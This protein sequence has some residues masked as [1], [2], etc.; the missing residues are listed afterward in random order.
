[1]VRITPISLGFIDVD[2]IIY[3]YI[4]APIV[5]PWVV[6]NHLCI[7]WWLTNIDITGDQ[8]PTRD[9]LHLGCFHSHGGAPIAVWLI[10]YGKAIYKWMMIVWGIP[11]SKKHPYV[12]Y[13]Y[14]RYIMVISMGISGS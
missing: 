13:V 2:S 3:I 11:I 1:M 9:L 14:S 6:D 10:S 7:L 12:P 4:Y 5:L 8:Q